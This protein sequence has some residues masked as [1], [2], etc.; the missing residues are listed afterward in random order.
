M[1]RSSLKRTLRRIYWTLALIL[2]ISFTAKIAD[3]VAFLN[4]TGVEKL[5]KDVYE[6]LRDMALLIATGGVAYITNV[7]QRRHAFLENL[8]AEWQDIIEAKTA[9]LVYMH[10]DT[11]THTDYVS[12]FT[13]LSETIDNM[14]IVYRNVGETDE[15]IG[16]FPYA[17]LHDM[18]R[19]LQTLDPRTA[20]PTKEQ[21][22][23]ARDAMLQSFYALRDGFLEELDLEEPDTPILM[24]G[25]R[26]LRKSGAATN[27]RRTQERQIARH[28]RARPEP[29]EISTLLDK[30]YAEEVARNARGQSQH[31]RNGD[32]NSSA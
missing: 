29:D 13:R 7:F 3:H 16:L 4:G 11:P 32:Q 12:A 26:R 17:P 9:L 25:A 28:K 23:L 31:N 21:R 30:L 2:A 27:A 5:L 19:V 20:E 8:K 24:S 1:T 14:R 18:R 10:K 22:K 15:D 6:F